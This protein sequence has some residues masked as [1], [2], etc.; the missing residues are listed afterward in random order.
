MNEVAT[1][2]F[3]RDQSISSILFVSQSGFTHRFTNLSLVSP[4]Q[5]IHNAMKLFFSFFLVAVFSSEQA[6]CKDA[7]KLR[8][9]TKVEHV[10]RKLQSSNSSVDDYADSTDDYPSSPDDR[11][12][13][14]SLTSIDDSPDSLDSPDDSP[15]SPDGRKLQSIVLTSIDEDSPND[16]SSPSSDEDSSLDGT[17]SVDSSPDV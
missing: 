16:D 8:Q 5:T 4:N 14:S 2:Y 10:R 3:L 7:I 9:R 12:T 17:Q 6:L 1:K 13:T 11:N 15:S